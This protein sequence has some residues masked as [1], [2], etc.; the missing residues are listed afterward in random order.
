MF[1]RAFTLAALSALFATG[2][3][4]NDVVCNLKSNT[5][6]TNDID[7]LVNSLNINDFSPPLPSSVLLTATNSVAF[8]FGSLQFC[9]E[10]DFLPQ[11]T[12]VVPSDLVTA[13]LAI[14]AQCCTLTSETC[15]QSQNT[16]NGDDG[17]SII[18]TIQ[19]TSVTCKGSVQFSTTGSSAVGDAVAEAAGGLADIFSDKK[20]AV[21]FKG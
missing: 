17:L 2:V 8:I 19:P 6:Q 13:V 10:N 9:V 4:S 16:F 3:Y 12:H 1:S 11:N 21:P 15:A 14:E 18:V 20:R 5:F 7:G